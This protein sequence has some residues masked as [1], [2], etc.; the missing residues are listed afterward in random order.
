MA[1]FDFAK[2]FIE[3][4]WNPYHIIDKYS[5]NVLDSYSGKA[6]QDINKENLQFQKY[7]QAE[8]WKREDNAVQRR[9]E[10]LERAGLSKTLAAGSA[11]GAVLTKAPEKSASHIDRQVQTA[12]TAF[13]LLKMKK[14]ISKADAEINYINQQSKYTAEKTRTESYNAQLQGATIKDRIL[15]VNKELKGK[16]LDNELK[17][18]NNEI[19]KLYGKSDR[20]RDSL[21][22]MYRNQAQAYTTD[23]KKQEVIAKKLMIEEKKYNL[24]LY[25]KMGVPTNIGWDRWTRLG[26]HVKGAVD[27]SYGE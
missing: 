10:D 12:N 21:Y 9:V 23:S 8:T 19:Q 24:G 16:N 5:T 6:E 11:A 20:E 3:S 4:D 18:V 26:G 2:N 1:M 22:K 14:D 27:D 15:I 17:Y 25:K 7:T 13:N